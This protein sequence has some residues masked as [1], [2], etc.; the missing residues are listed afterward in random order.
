MVP[1]MMLPG[2]KKWYDEIVIM[3]AEIDE[4]RQAKDEIV[5]DVCDL[6]GAD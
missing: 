4:S 6:P 5:Y 2:V 1:V 3:R